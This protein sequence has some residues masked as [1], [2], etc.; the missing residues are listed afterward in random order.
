MIDWSFEDVVCEALDIDKSVLKLKS[1]TSEDST[2]A[3]YICYMYLSRT[4]NLTLAKIGERYGGREHST[5]HH[6]LKKYK[7]FIEIKHLRFI[8]AV[9]YFN[10]NVKIVRHT[11]DISKL[12]KD[13]IHAAQFMVKQ[14]V[15]I[16]DIALFYNVPRVNIE[17]ILENKYIIIDMYKSYIEPK[18]IS[19]ILNID[20]KE[21]VRV[22][23]LARD[24]ERRRGLSRKKFKK[25]KI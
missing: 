22:S 3:R 18:K 14:G 12:T 24:L 19:E 20:Y 17:H 15:M 10:D 23:N 5:V 21:V 9:K 2:S 8:E 4:T 6:G 11:T 25:Q 1:R 7:D 16:K 13:D